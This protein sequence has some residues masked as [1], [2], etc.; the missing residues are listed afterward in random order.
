MTMK[1]WLLFVVVL[2][3]VLLPVAAI[4]FETQFTAEE[5]VTIIDNS[6]IPISDIQIFNEGNDPN[7]S[8]GRPGKYT[9]KASWVD[10]RVDNCAGTV[11]VFRNL[12]SLKN[13]KE[14][15]LE[16]YEKMPFLAQYI[17]VY[18]NA[19]IRFDLE[20]LPSQAK[21][22]EDLFSTEFLF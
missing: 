4:N 2:V 8:L 17:L 21:D 9:G 11:E 10:T 13:R 6:K 19:L 22:Y 16:I 7:E 12:D 5:I 18:E 3:S 15:L 1:T 20:L 14:Y